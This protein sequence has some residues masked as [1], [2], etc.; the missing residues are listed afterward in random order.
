MDS[1]LR[2]LSMIVL[3]AKAACNKHPWGRREGLKAGD[4]H[5]EGEST[6]LA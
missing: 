4:K 5:E 3:I 6:S 2:K 1:T